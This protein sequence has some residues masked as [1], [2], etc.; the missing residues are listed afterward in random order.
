MVSTIRSSLNQV[1]NQSTAI[2]FAVGGLVSIALANHF[3]NN[4][5]YIAAALLCTSSVVS[6]FNKKNVSNDTPQPLPQPIVN[7]TS[8]YTVDIS[9]SPASALKL[10]S[11]RADVKEI[12]FISGN[13]LPGNIS[14]DV[15]KFL[16]KGVYK[17]DLSRCQPVQELLAVVK[18]FPK[19]LQQLRVSA[20]AASPS[21]PVFSALSKTCPTLKKMDIVQQKRADHSSLMHLDGMQSLTSLVQITL[22]GFYI[23]VDQVGKVPVNLKELRMSSEVVSHER[24]AGIRLAIKALKQQRPNLKVLDLEGY[25]W[26]P[27]LVTVAPTPIVPPPD[28]HHSIG[29]YSGEERPAPRERLVAK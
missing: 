27:L 25:P 1:F 7:S 17:L 13:S 3:K 15:T 22:R 9:R 10:L 20:K 8:S 16:P 12:Q 21:S 24:A 26:Q 28:V 4:L 5:G 19:D 23:T 6:Y 2:P 11:Q 18:T 29:H 14:S